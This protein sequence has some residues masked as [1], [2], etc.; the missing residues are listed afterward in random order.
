MAVRLLPRAAVRIPRRPVDPGAEAA[1]VGRTADRLDAE[2]GARR[3]LARRQPEPVDDGEGLATAQ[4]PLDSLGLRVERGGGLEVAVAP[5]GVD[6]E[7][8]IAQSHEQRD[9]AIAGT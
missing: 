9:S 4:A 7:T 1:R 8:F 6:I 5:A 2:Q 3:R